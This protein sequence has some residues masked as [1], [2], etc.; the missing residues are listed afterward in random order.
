MNLK[1]LR[2]T[3]GLTQKEVSTILGIPLRTI[4]RYEAS[5][6]LENSFKYQQIVEKLSKIP[7]K[8]KKKAKKK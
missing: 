5:P 6:H 1:E 8:P 7:A 4:K 2:I 3:K